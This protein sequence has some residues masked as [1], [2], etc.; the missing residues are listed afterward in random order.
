MSENFD[1]FEK[2][3]DAGKPIDALRCLMRDKQWSLVTAKTFLVGYLA[4]R[5]NHSRK[6]GKRK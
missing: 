1:E 5:G 6:I 2:L 4:G 3:L